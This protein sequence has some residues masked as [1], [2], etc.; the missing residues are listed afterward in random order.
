MFRI[1]IQHRTHH[2]TE[3]GDQVDLFIYETKRHSRKGRAGAMLFQLMLLS[4]WSTSDAAQG[5]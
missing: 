4:T 2:L 1:S 3:D 5:S